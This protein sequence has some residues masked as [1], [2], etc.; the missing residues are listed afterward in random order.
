MPQK[1][2]YNIKSVFVLSRWNLNK[3]S[4]QLWGMPLKSCKKTLTKGKFNPQ[5]V[6]Y[7]LDQGQTATPTG[8]KP[9]P[10]CLNYFCVN[11]KVLSHIF[12]TPDE[13]HS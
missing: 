9:F 3:Q 2:R 1:M 8:E 10:C 4:F 6:V 7:C 11:V 12:A 13:V 5:L